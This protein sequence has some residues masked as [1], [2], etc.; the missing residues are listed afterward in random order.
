MKINCNTV[1][2]G[3]V[4]RLVPYR[5]EHVDIYHGWMSDPFLQQTTESEPLR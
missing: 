1:I 3:V 4:V 2:D 5:A